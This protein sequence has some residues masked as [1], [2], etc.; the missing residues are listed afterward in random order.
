MEL[1]TLKPAPGATKKRKRIGRGQGS[2]RGGTS[3]KGH[4]G[5]QSRSGYTR[6]RGSEGGQMPLKMRIPKFGFK[7]T[8][9]VTYK[10]IN[11]HTL[12]D[13]SEQH[14]VTHIGQDMLHEHGYVHKSELYKILGQGTLKAKLDVAAHACSASAQ[15][16]IE[17]AGGTVTI[18][19]KHK[20]KH[21]PP[22]APQTKEDNAPAED[23]PKDA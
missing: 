10:V 2:G 15:A 11:L 16:A 8:N 23:T 17:Q 22:E 13:L 18:I 5:A 4:K 1:H 21:T 19:D 9:R 12:Q 6:N 3:T 14:N 20:P 7:R